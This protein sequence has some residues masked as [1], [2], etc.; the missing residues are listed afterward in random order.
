M[1]RDGKQGDVRMK[2]L[3]VDDE[4]VSRKKMEKIMSHYGEVISVKNGREALR[5][6]T[7]ALTD[8][9]VFDLITLDISMPEMDGTEVLLRI[10]EI[11]QAQG[12]SKKYRVKVLMLTAKADRITVLESI[13]AG[14][15]D[16]LKK[17]FTI[18]S[19]TTKLKKIGLIA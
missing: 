2:T 14:C 19:I 3:I 16:Y 13:S 6:Y 5:A 15:D 18:E 1:G 17:P 11:E 10:R 12:I 8:I 4:L 7:E 9:R